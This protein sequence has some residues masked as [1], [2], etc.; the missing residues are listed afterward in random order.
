MSFILFLM[1]YTSSVVSGTQLRFITN[2]SS[3][4]IP[5]SLLTAE[6]N[7]SV[8]NSSSGINTSS[9]ASSPQSIISSMRNAN[10]SLPVPGKQPQ[11]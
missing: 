3:S 2:S 8:L 11:I 4:Y 1:P 10:A 5:T 7:S 9:L 6:I